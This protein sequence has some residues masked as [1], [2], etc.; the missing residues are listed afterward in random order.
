VAYVAFVMEMTR[1][2]VKPEHLPFRIA[3]DLIRIGGVTGGI[4]GEIEDPTGSVWTLL[5]FMDGSRSVGEMVT[6]V[7]ARHPGETEDAVR[8]A[9][10]VMIGSGYVEDA[11]HP[12]PA[13]LSPRE[14]ERYSRSRNY[15]R[16]VDLVPRASSW[17]PQL[18]LRRARVT[19]AGIGGTG[20][21]AAMALAATGVG[22]LHCVDGDTVE[23]SN[24]NRQVLFDEADV[25][26]AKVDA[27]VRRLQRLNSDISVTGERLHIQDAEDMLPLAKGCDVL[28][29]AADNP[30]EMTVW[31]NRACLAAGTPWVDAGYH[32][33]VALVGSY[34][35]G[36]SACWECVRMTHDERQQPL[37]ANHADAIR[38]PVENAVSAT[39]AGLS[40]ILAGQAVISLLTGVPP[41]PAGQVQ[42]VSLVQPNSPFVNSSERRDDCPGCGQAAPA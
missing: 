3:G 36:S 21:F 35:P 24:L 34:V 6:D 41:V 32:G 18:A 31:T 38:R 27:A 23:L 2:R 40:G 12:D 17:E 15:F 8:E 5:E 42:A 13:E 33:P 39:S 1:P 28:L 25:G 37:E 19:V 9:I 16:W 20:G 26:M 29:L 10:E 22:H 7:M 30:P 11:G 14:K 4:A